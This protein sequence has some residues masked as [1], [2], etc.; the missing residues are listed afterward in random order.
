[1]NTFENGSFSFSRE[2]N[3]TYENDIEQQRQINLAEYERRLINSE[4]EHPW[5]SFF[6]CGV[7]DGK[8]GTW[9]AYNRWCDE[10]HAD[11]W[12]VVYCPIGQTEFHE[13]QILGVVRQEVYAATDERD[14]L[15]TFQLQIRDEGM[16]LRNT[17]VLNVLLYHN[18]REVRPKLKLWNERSAMT[19]VERQVQLPEEIVEELFVMHDTSTV[20]A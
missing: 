17:H 19:P 2:Q 4:D 11:G 6:D 20:A 13:V 16:G 18:D 15:T 8:G 9:S 3:T 12:R 7:R 5:W 10:T 14:G 1:M